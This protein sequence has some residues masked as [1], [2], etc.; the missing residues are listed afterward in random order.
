DSLA[1][2]GDFLRQ[3]SSTTLGQ[4]AHQT[5]IAAYFWWKKS[6]RLGPAGVRKTVVAD[7]GGEDLPEPDELAR[8]RGP[9]AVEAAGD[10]LVDGLELALVDAAPEGATGDDPRG[11]MN[12]EGP[13]ARAGRAG[14][15]GPVPRILAAGDLG[16]LGGEA[17][18]DG[19]R[20]LVLGD[21]ELG[22]LADV[23][24][25]P[26]D[27]PESLGCDVALRVGA[28]EPDHLIGRIAVVI[29]HPLARDEGLV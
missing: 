3:T 12:G 1:T 22:V 23:G 29:E 11:G 25:P 10:C 21:A 26:V 17:A 16:A 20:G 9:R 28:D 27:Y 13:C 4:S 18:V 7:A 2:H 6:F 24:E 5:L 14:V 8:R 19:I 15:E